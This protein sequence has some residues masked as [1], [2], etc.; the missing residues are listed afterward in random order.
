MS[1]KI[2]KPALYVEVTER[3]RS[4]IAGG[5]LEPGAWIDEQKLAEELGV[6]R[7]PFREALRILASEGLLRIEPRRG[8]YVTELTESDL[9]EI[10]PLMALLEG[11][12]AYEAA[13]RITDQQIGELEKLHQRLEKHAK[14]KEIDQYYATNRDIHV[15]IQ[16]LASNE[17]LTRMVQDLRRILN[18]SRH[19][20]LHLNGR[21]GQSCAEHLAIFAALKARDGAGAE[22]AMKNHI[23]RQRE[24]LK[25]LANSAVE[26][27]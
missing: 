15:A 19:R 6:S 26:A 13:N 24:A 21:I 3:L 23:M 22:I 16:N 9:D 8:C 4:M 5:L 1:L 27:V 10:F 7:T 18:L 20:S 25:V 14:A 2:I 12:C 17:W 11:R